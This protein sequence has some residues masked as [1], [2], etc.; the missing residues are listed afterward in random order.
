MS[1][2]SRT[3]TAP[4]RDHDPGHLLPPTVDRLVER[5]APCWPSAPL[6]GGTAGEGR[7]LL[8]P[9]LAVLALAVAAQ[10]VLHLLNWALMDL[11]IDRLHADLDGSLVGWSGTVTTWSAALAAGLL[12]LLLQGARTP[13]LVLAA[14]CAFLSLDDMVRLHEVVAAVLRRLEVQGDTSRLWPFVYLPLLCLVG[15]LLLRTA[16]SVDLVTGRHLVAGLGCLVTAVVLE[17]ALVPLLF[18]LGAD[19][20]SGA[21][22]VEVGV[23]EALE[24]TGW[25]LIAFALLSG[26]VDLLLERGAESPSP[27]DLSLTT[28]LRSAVPATGE[29]RSGERRRTGA[30]AS[31]P[32][33]AG[34]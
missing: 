21:Y 11:R 15:W 18:G 1:A 31:S 14:A 8:R 4:R 24:T 13:M 20:A 23:E 16:R 33:G 34:R 17:A 25:G 28:G 3:R 10:S 29:R 2:L 12:A 7:R 19:S 5:T 30:S 22:A 32:Q 26:A 27:A 9:L 6:A